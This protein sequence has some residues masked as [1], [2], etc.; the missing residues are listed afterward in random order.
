M[1][2]KGR[3]L[4]PQSQEMKDLIAYIKSLAK[5]AKKKGPKAD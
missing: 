1:A 4:D 5:K 2:N 3:P